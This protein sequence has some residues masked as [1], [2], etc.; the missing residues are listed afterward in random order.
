MLRRQGRETGHARPEAGALDGPPWLGCLGLDSPW[1]G[2]LGLGPPW[3][4]CLGLDSPWLGRLGLR[5]PWLGRLGLGP[6]RPARRDSLHWIH[7]PP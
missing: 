5:S 1:L 2:C 7:S 3:L 6:A 4:G